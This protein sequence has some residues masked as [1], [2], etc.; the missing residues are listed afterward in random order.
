MHR[1]KSKFTPSQHGTFHATEYK[2]GCIM[3]P[4]AGRIRQCGALGARTLSGR[5]V[6]LDADIGKHVAG[7]VERRYPLAAII[8]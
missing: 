7:D 3:H 2:C 4:L 1:K 8:P 5:Y 6:K